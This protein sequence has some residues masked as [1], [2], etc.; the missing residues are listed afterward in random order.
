MEQPCKERQ[1]GE[2]KAVQARLFM[3]ATHKKSDG[4]LVFMPASGVLLNSVRCLYAASAHTQKNTQKVKRNLLTET[5]HSN[6]AG[7]N[8]GISHLC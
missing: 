5:Y 2:F 4:K 1:T 3:P 6:F 8:Y 7:N